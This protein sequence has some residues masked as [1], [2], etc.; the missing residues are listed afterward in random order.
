MS[1]VAEAALQNKTVVVTGASGLIGTHLIRRLNETGCRIV[2]AG[3]SRGKVRGDIAGPQF[4]QEIAACKPDIIFHLAAQTSVRV[5][6][7]DPAADYRVNTAWVHYLMDVCRA[8][9]W[10]PAVI[11]TGTVTQCGPAPALPVNEDVPDQPVT[12]YDFHKWMAEQMLEFCARRGVVRSVCLRLPNVYGPGPEA[13][14]ADRGVLNRM[15]R[16]ALAG[17]TLKIYGAGAQVRDYLYVEDCA[18]ALLLAAL[19]NEE[20]N[21][22]HFVLGTGQGHS[23]AEAFKRVQNRVEA[24]TGTAARIESVEPPVPATELE[25]RNFVADAARFMK[26]TGWRPKFSL[27]EGIDRTI[28]ESQ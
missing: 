23:I 12:I 1:M 25:N 15:I 24:L 7:Q 13:S 16:T 17:G 18:E 5:A 6:E 4:W 21:G 20:L 26:A 28:Q 14:A 27:C 10:Q 11:F 22:R 2:E 8:A 3:R 19:H 9:K